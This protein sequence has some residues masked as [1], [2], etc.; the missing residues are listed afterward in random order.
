MLTKYLPARKK[1]ILYP[2]GIIIGFFV[3]LAIAPSFSL[4]KVPTGYSNIKW[5]L[6]EKR[7]NITTFLAEKKYKSIIPIRAQMTLNHNI[8]KVISVVADNDRKIEWVPSLVEAST[9]ESFSDYH[10]IDFARYNAPWPLY[11]RYFVLDSR[12]TYDYK[13]KEFILLAYSVEHPKTPR[14]RKWVE[15]KTYYCKV[16]VKKLGKNKT[17]LDMI[18]ITDLKGYIPSWIV[19]FVQKKWP[20]N[21]LEGLN[22]QL[23]RKDIKPL[24]EFSIKR[25]LRQHK[26]SF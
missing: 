6:H 8:Q 1:P 4:T 13:K 11:D 21:T 16:V 19:N 26:T 17:F 25:F 10:R 22:L 15:G 24:P 12:A 14:N 20:Y 5:I 9:V 3:L 23:S 2:N 7:E 18:M